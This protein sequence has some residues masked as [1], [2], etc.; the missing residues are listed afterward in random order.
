MIWGDVGVDEG[1]A[2]HLQVGT[3]AEDI[4]VLLD[5]EPTQGGETS[6]LRP[7]ESNGLDIERFCEEGDDFEAGN[8]GGWYDEACDGVC[9]AKLERM[10]FGHAAVE[11]RSEELVRDIEVEMV[12]TVCGRNYQLENMIIKIGFKVDWGRNIEM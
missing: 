5:I 10:E 7:W 9:R 11:N 6:E 8:V 2:V 12:P 1:H 3:F 4:N